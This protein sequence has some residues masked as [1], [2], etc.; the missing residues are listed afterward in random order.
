MRKYFAPALAAV[1]LVLGGCIDSLGPGEVSEDDR[2]EILLV[3]DESGF[4]SDGFGTDGLA[5]NLVAY[6]DG[7]AAPRVWGR[8]RGLPVR[9]VVEVVFDREAGT[10]MVTKTVDFE[11]EFLVRLDDGSVSSKP[12]NEQLVQSALLER[13]DE[14]RLNDRT[15]RRSRWHLLEISPKEFRAIDEAKRTVTI[16]QVRIVVNGE[17]ALEI[18]DPAQGLPIEDGGVLSLSEGDEVSVYADV[19]NG[20]LDIENTTYV[21]LHVAHARE[22]AVGWRRVAMEYSDDLGQWVSHWVVYHAGREF[23]VV[24]ALDG[25][26]FDPEGEYRANMWGVPYR[27]GESD[28]ATTD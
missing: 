3:L 7:A 25:G 8:R 27:V 14:D 10:A 13:L 1:T 12:L 28:V 11:G 23:V 6:L 9:R 2:E 21:Y 4:F 26:S 16:E 15:G 24:D 22:D 19:A 17:T 20:T 5:D 18:V